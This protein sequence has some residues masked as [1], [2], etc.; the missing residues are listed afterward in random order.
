MT[1]MI[2]KLAHRASVH[3]RSSKPPGENDLDP[4]WDKWLTESQLPIIALR[5]LPIND[6]SPPRDGRKVATDEC[7][8]QIYG[9]RE[10]AKKGLLSQLTSAYNKLDLENLMDMDKDGD[11]KITQ[12][13]FL[14][15]T[16]IRLLHGTGSTSCEMRQIFAQLDTDG[17]GAIDQ[18]EI[19]QAQGQH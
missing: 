1:G 3:S 4:V 16:K 14:H 8:E 15:G 5:V 11:G 9:A 10:R 2:Q 12:D 13:E 17:S 19:E 6:D 7:K 18:H